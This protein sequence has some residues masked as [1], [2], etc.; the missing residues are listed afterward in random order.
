M[1]PIPRWECPRK[2]GPK[3]GQTRDGLFLTG[4]CRGHGQW[5][6]AGLQANA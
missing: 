6:A 5:I 2:S 4:Y 1:I 3:E